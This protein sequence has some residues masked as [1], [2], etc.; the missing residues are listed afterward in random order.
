MKVEEKKWKWI[1]KKKKRFLGMLLTTLGAILLANM[2]AG[3]G[4]ISKILWEGV[5]KAG[6][7]TIR[8]GQD[9]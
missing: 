6:D 4:Q 5:V 2:L 7:G 8:P 9:F 3:K 1:K